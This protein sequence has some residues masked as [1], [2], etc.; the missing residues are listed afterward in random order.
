MFSRQS[1]Q[2]TTFLSFT[3]A[4]ALGFIAWGSTQVYVTFCAPS[5]MVGF[6]QSLVTMDSSPCQ[7]IFSLIAH[8]QVLYASTITSLLV[9]C[10]SFVTSFCARHHEPVCPPCLAGLRE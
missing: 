1:L 9:A 3:S 10:I 7:A 2:N 4:L 5:G 6:F 8:S